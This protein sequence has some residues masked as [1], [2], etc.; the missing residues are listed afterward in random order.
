MPPY[1]PPHKRKAETNIDPPPKRKLVENHRNKSLIIPKIGNKFVIYQYAKVNPKTGKKNLTFPGGGCKKGENRRNCARRELAEETGLVV[2]SN[3]LRHAFYFPNANRENYKESNLQR[4]LKVTN[5][6]HGYLLP[7]NTMF[8]NVIR[9]FKTSKIKNN[10]LN[11]VYL[12]SRNNLNKS[13][14]VYKFSKTALTFI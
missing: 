12:M 2:T 5:H 10:E 11:N 14:R 3:K 8:N 4:G 7:L 13:N 1:A 9:T 6:Y